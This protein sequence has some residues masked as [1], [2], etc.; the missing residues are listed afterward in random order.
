MTCLTGISPKTVTD[1][2]A[3]C[4]G[5][6]TVAETRRNPVRQSSSVPEERLSFERTQLMPC[7]FGDDPSSAV[8]AKKASNALSSATR[9][10]SGRLTLSAKQ[11]QLLISSGLIKGTT[12]LLVRQTCGLAIRDFA[13]LPLDGD[14]AGQ[15]REVSSSL[16][17]SQSDGAVA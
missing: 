1:H 2:A 14:A 7:L 11:T 17:E 4:S 10:K 5:G 12:P 9:D 6:T 16:N 3:T 13:S 15:Q 8:T